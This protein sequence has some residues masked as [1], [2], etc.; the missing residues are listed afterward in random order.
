MQKRAAYDKRTI[1][2]QIHIFSATLT[3]TFQALSMSIKSLATSHTAAGLPS[4]LSLSLC[5]LDTR[6]L[7]SYLSIFP[8][9]DVPPTRLHSN[10]GVRSVQMDRY[11]IRDRSAN[12][13]SDGTEPTPTRIPPSMEAVQA[14]RHDTTLFV[15]LEDLEI[16]SLR[17]PET[18]AAIPAQWALDDQRHEMQALDEHLESI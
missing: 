5:V 16:K 17:T 10:S 18:T 9:R 7:A 11:F 15:N 13:L 1:F 4:S 12:H 14:H 8:Q 2:I 6:S 3:A